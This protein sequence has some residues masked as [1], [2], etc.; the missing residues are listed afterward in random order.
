MALSDVTST[1]YQSDGN[2]GWHWVNQNGIAQ[3]ADIKAGAAAAQ[4]DGAATNILATYMASEPAVTVTTID[5]VPTVIGRNPVGV[6]GIAKQVSN[7]DLDAMGIHHEVFPECEFPKCKGEGRSKIF[8][9]AGRPLSIN[10]KGELEFGELKPIPPRPMT[11]NDRSRAV[12]GLRDVAGPSGLAGVVGPSGAGFVASQS[13]KAFVS[14]CFAHEQLPRAEAKAEPK[15]F[16]S[17]PYTSHIQAIKRANEIGLRQHRDP[18]LVPARDTD[19]S[20]VWF[21]EGDD[22]ATGYKGTLTEMPSIP[23]ANGPVAAATLISK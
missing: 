12:A 19:N 6:A 15:R 18:R 2:G 20:I 7:E 21:I 10:R 23:A 13:P 9:S 14:V 5:G 11:I 1:S 3:S 17:G 8:S 4:A 22:G 16:R